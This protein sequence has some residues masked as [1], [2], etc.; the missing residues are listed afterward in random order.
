MTSQTERERWERL[1]EVFEVA[2]ELPPGARRGYLEA[3]ITE[4]ALRSE[5]DALLDGHEGEGRLDGIAVALAALSDDATG[6]SDGESS[7]VDAPTHIGPYDILRPIAHGG[8]GTVHLARHVDGGE[9]VAVKLLRTDV[10]SDGV[11]R[12]FLAERQ[13]LSR[14]AHS[15]I[16]RL[17]DDGV[18][19]NGLPYFVMEYVDGAPIDQYCD[20]ARLTVAERLRLFLTVCE[21]VEHA[22]RLHVVHRDLKPAN[23]LV[24]TGGEAILLDFGI[25]KILDRAAFPGVGFDTMTGVQL[26]TLEYASPEQLLAA[27]ITASSDV[28]QLG[29]LL[30]RLLIGR[31]PW[32]GSRIPSRMPPDTMAWHGIARPSEAL[33]AGTGEPQLGRHHGPVPGPAE[34]AAA[35]GTTVRGLSALLKGSLDATTMSAL[36]EEPTDR[37]PSVA[38]VAEDVRQYLSGRPLSVQSAGWWSAAGGVRSRWLTAAALMVPLSLVAA[39]LAAYFLGRG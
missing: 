33:R 22:H 15:N 37:Y 30:Y 16:A 19:P 7:A 4:P 17:L 13:I 12:R 11:R 25:A 34:V 18:T 8:M 14:M 24:T 3:T 9:Q 32:V 23:I 28:Y 6:R 1:Q 29:L 36:A 21:A 27:P 5:V 10:D 35:R 38:L 20:D 26:L 31:L 39:V 2:L